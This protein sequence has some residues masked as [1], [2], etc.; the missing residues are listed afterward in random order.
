LANSIIHEKKNLFINI[1]F[2][3]P[4]SVN[5]LI[6]PIILFFCNYSPLPIAILCP[7]F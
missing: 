4:Q 5:L 7:Y 1:N 6:R 3:V 2:I